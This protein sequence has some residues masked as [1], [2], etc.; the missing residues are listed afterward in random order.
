MTNGKSFCSREKFENVATAIASCIAV[1]RPGN[2]LDEF[3]LPVIVTLE[4]HCSPPQ[5]KKIATTMVELL[6]DSLLSVRRCLL[7]CVR[8]GILTRVSLH[9]TMSSS[10]WG[11]GD[12]FRHIT[13]S[14]AC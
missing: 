12:P 8:T 9:S 13:C 4:M 14:A 11:E 10:I 2:R 1:N 7:E 3:S 5:Q 6:G